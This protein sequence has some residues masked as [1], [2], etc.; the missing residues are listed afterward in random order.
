L[1]GVRGAIGDNDA[2]YFVIGSVLEG[3]D[4][5]VAKS[6]R[7]RKTQAKMKVKEILAGYIVGLETTLGFGL[8]SNATL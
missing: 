8:V 4:M 2:Q 6:I 1:L 5:L 7:V 3:L